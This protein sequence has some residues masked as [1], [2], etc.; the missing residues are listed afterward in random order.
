MVRVKGVAPSRGLAHSSLKR[1]RLLV[2][3]HPHRILTGGWGPGR[4]AYAPGQPPGACFWLR[5]PES[6]GLGPAY[7]AGKML[8]LP[9]AIGC[10]GGSRTPYLRVMSPASYRC[11]TARPYRTRSCWYQGR[12]S[13]PH[14]RFSPTVFE[15]VVSTDSSHP[16]VVGKVGAGTGTRTRPKSLEDSCAGPY[17]LPAFARHITRGD[18]PERDSDAA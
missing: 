2:S 10:A 13:N 16:G 4:V 11:S 5:E 3:P 9:P 17:T 8:H 7:E 15:T 12:D 6:H 1:A 18:P 14:G